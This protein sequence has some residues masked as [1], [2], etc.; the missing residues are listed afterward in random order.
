M[1]GIYI[2]ECY[3]LSKHIV[4]IYN[5]FCPAAF[6]TLNINVKRIYNKKNI[7]YPR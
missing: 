2:Y 5:R 6:K 1:G 3:I 7:L 4:V